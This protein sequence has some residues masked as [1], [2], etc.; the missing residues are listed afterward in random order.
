MATAATIKLEASQKP[1][2]YVE[3]IGEESAKLTSKLLQENHERHHVFFN[4]DGF[5]VSIHPTPRHS[6]LA[7]TFPGAIY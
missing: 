6:F 3:G 4:Q 7:S 5:H 1:E 2:F